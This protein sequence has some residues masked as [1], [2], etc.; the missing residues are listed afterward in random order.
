MF[1]L[2]STHFYLK[3]FRI[4]TILS[5]LSCR[6]LKKRARYLTDIMDYSELLFFIMNF[7]WFVCIFL[8]LRFKIYMLSGT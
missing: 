5:A 8:K 7:G 1:Y 6:L 4:V 2:I 3:D